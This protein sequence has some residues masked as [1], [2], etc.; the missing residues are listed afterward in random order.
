[1][2]EKRQALFTLIFDFFLLLLLL[3]LLLERFFGFAFIGSSTSAF[4]IQSDA[5]H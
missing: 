4:S 2:C 5:H 3:Y 1:M